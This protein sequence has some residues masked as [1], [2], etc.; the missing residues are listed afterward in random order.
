M[1][2]CMVRSSRVKRTNSRV[3]FT[4]G[5]AAGAASWTATAVPLP[6][7]MRWFL[8]YDIGITFF[9]SR[10]FGGLA[11]FFGAPFAPHFERT[12]QPQQGV[13]AAHDEGADQQRGHAPKGPEQQGILFGIVVGGMRQVS[14]EAPRG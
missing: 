9:S 3:S 13:D 10:G 12:R 8:L 4:A 11:S 1:Q 5:I 2:A 7:V 6:P 14:G